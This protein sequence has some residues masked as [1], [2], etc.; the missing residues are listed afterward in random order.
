MFGVQGRGRL[1]GQYVAQ[2]AGAR[3]RGLGQG[4]VASIQN[5]P[6]IFL[7]WQ[8]IIKKKRGGF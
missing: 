5:P 1:L 2:C 6:V 8:L 3:Y 7:R 4:T